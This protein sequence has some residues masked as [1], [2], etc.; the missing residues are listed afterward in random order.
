MAGI[1]PRCGNWHRLFQVKPSGFRRNKVSHGLACGYVNGYCTF[2]K[3]EILKG[4]DY[5]ELPDGELA[6]TDCVEYKYNDDPDIPEVECDC[7]GKTLKYDEK[8]Y[9]TPPGEKYCSDCI[10][11]IE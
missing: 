3:N 7:C 6:D 10:K 8:Y 1:T 11:V 2:C 9:I 5:Y 4:Y